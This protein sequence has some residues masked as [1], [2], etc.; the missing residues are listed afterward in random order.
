MAPLL[1]PTQ[2][3]QGSRAYLPVVMAPTQSENLA[4]DVAQSDRMSL[5]DHISKQ[6]ALEGHRGC[7]V[8]PSDEA[9]GA[10]LQGA[11]EK[12]GTGNTSS[13]ANLVPAAAPTEPDPG[14]KTDNHPV[15]KEE[16]RPSSLP[17]GNS[18]ELAQ[19]CIKCLG[20]VRPQFW[21]FQQGLG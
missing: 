10:D 13:V 11:L 19:G 6:V 4:R 7:Q 17:L 21:A 20:W 14:P 5:N 18:R 2:A 3:G 1:V 12:E 8:Q 9:A 16:G 15:C